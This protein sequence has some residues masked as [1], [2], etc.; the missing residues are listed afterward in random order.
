MYIKLVIEDA[1][2]DFELENELNH[3]DRSKMNQVFKSA[4]KEVVEISK[5]YL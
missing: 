3:V 1:K 5:Q 2:E 4:N